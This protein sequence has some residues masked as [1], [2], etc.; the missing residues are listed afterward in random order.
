MLSIPADSPAVTQS[1]GS[2]SAI[3][4]PYAATDHEFLVPSMGST[5]SSIG[6]AVATPPRVPR[7][8][9]D[10]VIPTPTAPAIANRVDYQTDFRVDTYPVSG[11]S[12]PGDAGDRWNRFLDNTILHESG[13]VQIALD[14]ARNYQRELGNLPPARDCITLQSQLKA[15]FDQHFA[16]I[17]HS[18]VQY[19]AETRHGRTQG[20]VFP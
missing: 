1:D 8:G 16:A 3:E 9:Y 17:D 14:G 4:S 10:I 15:L 19:D 20:A 2:N 5:G 12:M 6:Q 7:T 18:S 13:H 11:A